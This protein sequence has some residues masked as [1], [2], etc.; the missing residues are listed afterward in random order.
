MND[1][2]LVIATRNRQKLN[3]ITAIFQLPQLE[4]VSAFDYPDLPDVVEDGDT[5]EENAVKKARVL[6]LAT[7][8]WALA[9]DSGLEVDALGGA[10]G[11]YSARFAGEEKDDRANNTQLLSKLQDQDNR[12]ARFRC[13]VALASPSGETRRVEGRCEGTIAESERGDGG[14]GYD[15]VFIPEGHTQ[16]FA[17]LEPAEKHA[18]SHR[19]KALRAAHEKWGDMLASHPAEWP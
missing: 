12:G 17:E 13:V 15:P 11:V 16:T 8:C 14:F 18:V 7:G 9:D 4:I 5:F 10:P 19:G 3:E 1:M 6:A 2:K